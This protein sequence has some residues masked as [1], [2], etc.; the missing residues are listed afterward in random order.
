MSTLLRTFK[1]FK[2]LPYTRS[3]VDIQKFNFRY[4]S[5]DKFNV[6]AKGFIIADIDNAKH[7]ELIEEFLKTSLTEYNCIRDE[8]EHKEDMVKLSEETHKFYSEINGKLIKFDLKTSCN[9]YQEV[10]KKIV[11]F[12]LVSMLGVWGYG[13]IYK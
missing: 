12:L 11:S 4:L 8:K 2:L 1:P 13:L 6:S 10:E 3:I 5:K 9:K 7:R